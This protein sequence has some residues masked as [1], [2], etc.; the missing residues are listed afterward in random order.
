MRVFSTKGR[1]T[2]HPL[3]VHLG[4]SVNREEWGLFNSAANAL[5]D[6]FWPGPLTLLLPRTSRVPD[7]VT[8]GRESVAIRVPSH[9][10][11]QQLLKEVETGVVAPSANRFGKVSP[12]TAQHVVTD[13][14]DAV[15]LV[16]D[17][18]PCTI[19]VESTI[20]ECIG[21]TVTV[22]RP[23]AISSDDILQVTGLS[24][25]THD[26]DVRAP[27]MLASHYAPHAKVL[28]FGSLKDAT[29]KSQELAADGKKSRVLHHENTIIYAERLYAELRDADS[30][31][32]EI[33]CA[34][35]PPHNGVGEAIRDRLTKAAHG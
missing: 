9:P 10:V 22:L 26:V 32:V 8:G 33:I 5:A 4:S 16:L 35:L 18:G 7:W 6:V 29:D 3:I 34:V 28:L 17:G 21:D 19:G 20:V 31:E 1:P 24:D 14:G 13:L 15:D 25:G 27:G 2:S 11:A 30:E 23:G 12:T